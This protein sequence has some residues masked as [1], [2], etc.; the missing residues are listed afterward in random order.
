[1]SGKKRSWTAAT[2]KTPEQPAHLT[3]SWVK[4]SLQDDDSIRSREH[5]RDATVMAYSTKGYTKDDATS[6]RMERAA[7]QAPNRPVQIDAAY[8]RIKLED[9]ETSLQLTRAAS[10]VSGVP[11]HTCFLDCEICECMYQFMFHGKEPSFKSKAN[12]ARF[13]L[14]STSFKRYPVVFGNNQIYHRNNWTSTAKVDIGLNLGEKGLFPRE[15]STFEAFRPQSSSS[16]NLSK[17]MW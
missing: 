9:S 10:R 15:R 16:Q 7:R 4:K 5:L 14:S 17:S 13:G 8:P 1:M 11:L 3:K 2:L 12:Y 6:L